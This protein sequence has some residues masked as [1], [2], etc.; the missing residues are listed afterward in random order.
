MS[1]DVRVPSRGVDEPHDH[2]HRRRLA[3]SVWS[4]KAED[5]TLGDLE[6]DIT[7]GVDPPLELLGQVLTRDRS[8][9]QVLA[10]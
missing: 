3:R 5:N 8:V 7:D 2:A 10:G 1:E 9:C 6:G 4:E